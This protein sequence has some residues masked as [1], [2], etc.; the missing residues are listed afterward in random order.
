MLAQHAR[1]GDETARGQRLRVDA[2]AGRDHDPG[3]PAVRSEVH[4]VAVGEL[5]RRTAHRAADGHESALQG[6]EDLVRQQDRCRHGPRT[7]ILDTGG[8]R[9]SDGELAIP[10]GEGAR[11]PDQVTTGQA[12][13]RGRGE[14]ERDA[15]GR[16]LEVGA[17]A[18]VGE[19]ERGREHALHDDAR[20]EDGV[21]DLRD[22]RRP[23]G[24]LG[25]RSSVGSGVGRSVGSGVG[26][27]VGSGVGA[28]V[29]SGVGSG[30]GRSVGSGV[31]ASVG[32]GWEPLGGLGRGS[33]R[34]LGRRVAVG[35]LGRGSLR[36]LGCRLGCRALRWLRRGL[37]RRCR[38]R[39]D[40]SRI[41]HRL[42]LHPR[43]GSV[44]VGIQ[45]VPVI[46]VGQPLERCA[47][48]RCAAGPALDPP[49]R[50]GAP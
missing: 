44:V 47:G 36:G 43:V 10:R 17:M 5:I 6:L 18:G 2:A 39:V 20:P 3:T 31:G 33:L 37:G 4:G 35:G 32:S 21:P 11:G 25:R 24:G 9:E 48:R 29:G 12:R 27:S 28:S 30:V 49:A 16:V 13:P 50:R 22:G 26:R 7:E 15:S 8:R 40:M 41:R 1:D 23:L 14:V 19:A 42:R 46:T 38:L 34:G 45:P